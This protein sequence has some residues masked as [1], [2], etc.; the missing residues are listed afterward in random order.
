MD[1]I[2]FHYSKDLS[3]KNLEEMYNYFC[4]KLTYL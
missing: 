3:W 1:K 2:A 4:E